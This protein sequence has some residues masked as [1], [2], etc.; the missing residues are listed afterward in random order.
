V[1]GAATPAS[2]VVVERVVAVVGDEA[3]LLSQLRRRGEP[4]QRL[5]VKQVPAGA[6]RAAAESQMYRDLLAK[7]VEEEL[8]EQSAAK[9]KITVTAEEIDNALRTLAAQQGTTVGDLV[10]QV[11]Q[12][13]GLTEVA[14]REE[15]RRQVLEGKMLSLRVK[16]RIRI[17]EEEVRSTYQRALRD[18]RERREYRPAWVVLRILPGSS[19][20]A[21]AEREALATDIATRARAGE[22]FAALAAKYSDD[23]GTRE[24]GGDLGVRAPQKA[25]AAMA[26]RRQVLARELEE[27][28]ASLEPNDVAAPTRYGDAIVV[29]KLL[30]RQPSR[31]TDLEAAR[32]EMMQRLQNELLVKERAIWIEDLKRRTYVDVRL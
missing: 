10:R 23:S 17:T 14:Y 16:G 20:A 28:I 26:G 25:P 5:I 11:E 32:P 29:I 22:D 1:L 18:E 2:A 13:S 8:E 19:A 30:S 7:M 31:Y 27:V 24:K 6:Q 21:L 4:F 12:K 3:I 15:V 9:S